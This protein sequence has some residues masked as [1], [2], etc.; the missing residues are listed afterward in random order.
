MTINNV[1]DPA[2]EGILTY[3]D[4]AGVVQTV[5]A[6]SVLTPTEAATLM[7][8]PAMDF[9]GTVPP[10][11]YTVEDINGET[12]DA[13]ILIEVTPTPDAM[14]DPFTTNEDTPVALNPL[15]ND[16]LGAGAQSLTINNIPDPAVEGTLT[17]TD[18]DGNVVTVIAGSVLTPEEAA[19]LMFVPVEEFN[20]TVPPIGYTVT[21][22]NG[23]TSDAVINI[24]VT[25]TPDAVDDV[26][27]TSA[28]TPVSGNVIDNDTSFAGENLM[29]SEV[30]GVP[31][32][33]G[34]IETEF[35]T[36]E[37]AP[38]GTYTF[39]PI[40]GLSEPATFT[41]T[42]V[43]ENGAESEATVVIDIAAL[44][45]AKSVVGTPTL[46]ADGNFSV[47]YQL[48]VQNTG[49]LNLGD[50]SLVEDLSTQFGGGFV[51][52]GDLR[53]T[54]PAG[55]IGSLVALDS[56][57]DG[58]GVTE[59]VAAG[60]TL[61]AGDSFT[62]EFD[63]IVD[64]NGFGSV[65]APE[66]SVA[67]SGIAIDE[68]GAQVTD[69]NGNP[70]SVSDLSDSG[71]NPVGS[72]IGEPG[73][74]F[75]SDDATPLFIPS[76]GLAK[77][78]G[79]AVPNGDNFDVTFTLA[80]ENNGSVDLTDLNLFDDIASQFGGAF[81]SVGDPA[82]VNF[83]GTGTQPTINGDWIND[84]SETLIAG[85]IANVGDRF[86]IVFTA[87]I[88]PT[89]ISD[90]GSLANQA[91]ASGVALD[92]NGNRLT[93][94]N[95]DLITATDVSDNG[96]NPNNEN[97]EE[98]TGDGVFANDPTPIQIADLAI[99]K[100]IFGEPVLTQ[101]A[102]YV[103]TYQLVIENTGTLDLGSLSL[104]ED[105]TTQF[106]S[107]FVEAG[108][109]TL[110]TGPGD[111]GSS[112]SLDSS[113]NGDTAT[114]ILEGSENALV[115]GDSFT[116]RFDVEINPAEVTDPLE[117]SVEGQGTAVD[118]NG[119][120]VLD[121][122]N[123]PIVGTDTS[124][125]GLDPAT[126]NPDDPADQGTSAD[127]TLFDPPAVPL[128][129]ISGTVFQ[130]DNNDG[131]QQPG[132]GGI[133][134][135]EITLT[136]TDVFGNSVELTTLTGAGGGYAF[137]GLNAGT[138]TITQTQPDGFDDGIDFGGPL[139]TVGN[140]T[141]SN[142]SLTWGQIFGTNTFAEQ[143]QGTSGNPPRFPVLSPILSSPVGGL[144]G[145]FLVGPGPIYSGVPINTNANPLTLQS[146]R[147]IQGGY[148]VAGFV[149]ESDCGCPEPI[150]PCCQPTEQSVEQTME[151]PVEQ[152]INGDEMVVE[153][154][155]VILEAMIDGE[156]VIEDCCDGEIAIPAE[157]MIPCE[158]ERVIKRPSF[159]KRFNGWLNR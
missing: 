7:F 123:A 150:N 99:A 77:S 125:S 132:E 83:V 133:P 154:Q 138:Y 38:D 92:E 112:I 5:I 131:F 116:L 33:N 108:N 94:G 153:G 9:N 118:E 134:G 60:S 37:I 20:G 86:E 40:P 57:W 117:N 111:A 66:N 81:V 87:T 11:G 90:A 59:L 6:G 79:D 136:G 44:G 58:D 128:G 144:L 48:V 149:T 4:D 36:V 12:S 34:P 23:E 69:A 143:L 28:D 115:V 31:I 129:T 145:G 113:W 41:Y 142:I 30:N 95:G 98:V 78:A 139:S 25:P 124:D 80:F 42:V 13:Q 88:D 105:L 82:I 148:A 2:V 21:D 16:D 24:T 141:I 84:T 97:G 72:N 35:G 85:G 151:Q 61:A 65:A 96:T 120:P 109:L 119:S 47:T 127:P 93:D 74:T 101:F 8:E 102:N 56:S 32:G 62:L 114:E 89:G 159:L 64:A 39:T 155:G 152:V 55:S 107:A 51:S 156:V 140:D 52:T 75:G 158:D 68:N 157:E 43:D 49:S 100:S 53:I 46:L 18:A 71:T 121:S 67:G 54:N 91:T 29:V 70:V 103:V 10:I 22:I 146:S 122:N 17:Y 15:A 19:T 50:L 14:D 126:S 76:I 26:N 137:E 3:T 104:L 135:V 63:V 1:P 147:P 106:G 110:V 27:A 73:D 45:L 130:D